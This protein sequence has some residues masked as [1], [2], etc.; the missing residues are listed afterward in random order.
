VL[1]IA[2]FNMHCG[3]D[4]WGRPFDDGAA[5]ERLEA[6][7]VVLQESWTCAGESEGQAERIGRRL[8][9]TVFTHKLGEGRRIR[10]QPAASDRWVP[11]R[12]WSSER[13]P[14][15]FDGVRPQPDQVQSLARWREADR[16]IWSI[17]VLIG[18][19]ITVEDWRVLS[20]SQLR[21]DPVNRAVLVVDVKVDGRPVSIAGTHMPHLHFGSHS[22][23]AELR[24]GL[25]A[26]ARRDAV[27]CGDM[28]T[29]GPLV[30]VFMPGWKRAV[31]GRTWPTWRPHSQIDHILVRGALRPTSGEVL[32]HAGSDHRPVRARI[33]LG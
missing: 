12:A 11:H 32:P 26:S 29:W 4:G 5:V 9:A 33:D 21:R 1:T 19:G 10:P 16:G 8:G 20:F 2:S 3:I 27:L 24:A 15:Y 28:N 31:V 17:A 6:D 18:P 25:D 30:G 14:L 13:R 22:T 23:W 7:V